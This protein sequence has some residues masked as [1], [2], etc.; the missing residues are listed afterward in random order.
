MGH[1]P[2][3][4]LLVTPL[5]DRDCTRLS[6]AVM[7]IKG[8]GNFH[9][10]SLANVFGPPSKF[11]HP[12]KVPCVSFYSNPALPS[13]SPSFPSAKRDSLLHLCLGKE[14]KMAALLPGQLH[15]VTDDTSHSFEC[16]NV[17]VAASA[18]EGI[19]GHVSSSYKLIQGLVPLHVGVRRQSGEASEGVGFSIHRTFW[20]E[21]CV[22]VPPQL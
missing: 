18:S 4:F 14:R 5:R 9:L 1:L 10:T 12:G 2:P 15:F 20:M 16:G 19:Q 7:D 6:K 13:F 11:N 22:S 21:L 17:M 3:L 8:Q